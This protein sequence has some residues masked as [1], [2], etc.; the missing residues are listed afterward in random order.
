MSRFA[1]SIQNIILIWAHNAKH[2]RF[3]Q[4]D[5]LHVQLLCFN[6]GLPLHCSCQLHHSCQPV[7]VL[8][9]WKFATTRQSLL[10]H[11]EAHTFKVHPVG[12]ITDQI[13]WFDL[14]IEGITRFDTC[15][16]SQ[17][18]VLTQPSLCKQPEAISTHL[19]HWKANSLGRLQ[20]NT[21]RRLAY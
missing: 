9:K 21:S 3:T 2:C 19:P 13:L 8:S 20:P 12:N 15:E 5:I 6:I 1:F 14:V 18:C 10:K 11:E 4:E 7:Q 16:V 17:R